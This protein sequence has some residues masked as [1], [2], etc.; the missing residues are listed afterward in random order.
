MSTAPAIAEE[1]NNV[2]KEERNESL[3]LMDTPVFG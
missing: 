3:D 1:A 2:S